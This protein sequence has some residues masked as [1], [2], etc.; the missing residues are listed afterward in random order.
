MQRAGA[1]GVIVELYP[2]AT[3]PDTGDR[4][5]LTAFIRRCAE[6]GV[7]VATATPGA[8]PSATGAYQT[9]LAIAQA[10]GLFLRDMSAE[11]ATVKMMWALAQSQLTQSVRQLM[12]TPIAGELAPEA[13]ER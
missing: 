6:R 2:S 12:L 8:A 9:T 13:R 4:F 5:S 3:G 10:G 1:R 11:A 7:L